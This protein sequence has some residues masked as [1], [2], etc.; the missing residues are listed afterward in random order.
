MDKEYLKS[1][2]VKEATSIGAVSC[3]GIL[4]PT[5]PVDYGNYFDLKV[6][7]KYLKVVNFWYEN[8]FQVIQKGLTFPIKVR[9]DGDYCFI[10]DERIPRD[11]YNKET[12]TTCC[13]DRFKTVHQHLQD[14]IDEDCN[15]IVKKD[16]LIMV[17]R[18]AR[19]EIKMNEPAEL[20]N[21]TIEKDSLT[22]YSKGVEPWFCKKEVD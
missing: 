1:L 11:Y 14:L 13:P 6:E 22:F 4:N 8:L 17:N 15:V 9:V 18:N 21:I 16:N 7:G 12:L 2:E 3:V 20:P 5:F 19:P 10:A